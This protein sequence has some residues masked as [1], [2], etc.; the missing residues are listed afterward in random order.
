MKVSVIIPTYNRASFL[1]EALQSA[2]EQDHSDKEIIVVDDGS[3]DETENV[4]AEFSGVKYLKIK[5]A[6]VSKARNTGIEHSNGELIAFLDS[7]DLW[8]PGKLST[9]VDYF[10]KHPEISICQTEEIWVRNGKRVNPKNIHKKHSGWIFE[11]SIPLCVVSPSAVMIRKKV[12]EDVGRFDEEMPV[13]EDYELW[14]R[15]SLK[16]Q[17][18]TLPDPK[19]VK[20]GG[21]ADQLSKT[22]GMDIWRIY[23]LKKLLS[24]ASLSLGQKEL[25]EADIRRRSLIVAEGAKKRGNWKVYENMTGSKK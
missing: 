6:G 24:S 10:K 25:V 16:Y 8:L 1:R 3:M 14:L 18:I 22:W 15:F 2:A 4:V 7:D 12:F 21:H 11:R 13:C 17:V 5:H 20:R 19:I 9:Q 23:A